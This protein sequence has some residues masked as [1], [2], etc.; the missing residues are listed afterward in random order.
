[1]KLAIHGGAPIRT[2]P[3]PAYKVI[4]S[5]EKTA[6]NRV[7]DSNVLSKY[8]GCWHEDFYGGPEVQALEKEW[9][10]HFGV[11]HAMA[12]NSCTSGL[13]C[14]AGAIGIE[15]GDEVIVSPYTM[16]ASA[17]A[18]LIFNGIPVFA[19]IEEQ[20]FCLDPA[21]VERNITSRT[22]AI[23]VVD[24][25]GLPY[26]ADAINAIA[27]KH[28]LCVIE[29][30]AQ[31]PGAFYKG[32]AA[33]TLGDIGVY[34]LNYH[35]HIHCGEGGMVV[36]NDDTLAERVQLIRNHAEAVVADKGVKNINNMIGFNFRLPE[37]EAAITRCQLQKLGG[38]IKSRQDNCEYLAQRI[39][40]IP[41][42]TPAPIRQGCS[43]A[44]YVQPFL[45]NAE[46]AG[47]PRHTFIEAV[48]A[49]LPPTEMREGEGVLLSCGYVKPLY[50]QPL[51][52]RKIAYGSKGYPFVESGQASQVRYEK[53]MCPVTERMHEQELFLHEMM[54]P[55]M[56]A[57]DLNDVATAFEKVWG[58]RKTLTS[59]GNACP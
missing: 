14:A 9:A 25:F 59:S 51:Y 11:K 12:V 34:S 22:R 40:Q 3:F 5:E 31:A 15:P 13:Y 19:D 44:Y 35:K 38:L 32:R 48:R 37:L 16:S 49:E 10:A 46:E 55:G 33:G 52:Q 30:T 6:V 58:N 8:L 57:D 2:K 7:L 1:M 27:R 42:I 4:G 24:I 47:V 53:G 36:T 56:T 21:A 41:A 45:F 18:A 50:L 29:D 20:F 17:T 23:I 39:G 43:H 26:D 54:R 28:G